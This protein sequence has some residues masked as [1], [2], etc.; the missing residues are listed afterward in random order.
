MI[1]SVETDAP[2]VI[3]RLRHQVEKLSRKGVKVSINNHLLS[4]SQ[5]CRDGSMILAHYLRG[6]VLNPPHDS[7]S[8]APFAFFAAILLFGYGAAALCPSW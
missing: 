6:R 3:F 2:N 5:S 4:L 1:E 8:F 7:D